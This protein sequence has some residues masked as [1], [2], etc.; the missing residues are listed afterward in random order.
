MRH[1]TAGPGA[2]SRPWSG[3]SLAG[4]WQHAFFY[5]LVRHGGLKVAKPALFFVVLF[6]CLRPSIAAGAL[7][8][9]D[10]RF[11]PGSV[12]ARY[13][14]VFRL[15]WSFAVILLERASVG[16]TGEFAMT[17]SEKCTAA[18]RALLREGKGLIVLS[19]HTGA[20]QLALAGLC[21][22]TR[23][24]I[25]H[26]RNAGDNDRHF[27]EHAPDKN[28]YPISIIDPGDGFGGFV[29]MAAALHK[30]EI[31]CLMGDRMAEGERTGLV[32]GFM[33]GEAVFPGSAYRLASVTGAPVAVVYTT[34]T[35]PRRFTSRCAA[36]LRIPPKRDCSLERLRGFASLYA[37]TL[38]DYVREYPY[39]FFN[40]YNLWKSAA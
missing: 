24:H 9:L 3:R 35:G 26:P 5:L 21:A 16:I 39:Q 38:E 1:K 18:I 17:G 34:R 40:F 29:A 30:G 19:A 36:V 37:A 31:V 12:V 6:Y 2:A 10:R 14:R 33:G 15:F 32:T 4:R 20:W 13:L 11:G 25:V 28:A 27:F 8:Y 23:V 22:H 7:P